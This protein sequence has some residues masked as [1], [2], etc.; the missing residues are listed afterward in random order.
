MW[1]D[2]KPDKIYLEIRVRNKKMTVSR[3]RMTRRVNDVV[4]ARW[5]SG[6]FAGYQ[7][8]ASKC[9]HHCNPT[10]KNSLIH[11]LLIRSSRFR[12]C[13]L[14]FLVLKRCFKRSWRGDLSFSR[15][16][17]HFTVSNSRFLKN[18]QRFW[19]KQTNFWLLRKTN[20]LFLGEYFSRSINV[21]A[22]RAELF[23]LLGLFGVSML[24]T[25]QNVC[26]SGSTVF[27]P[28]QVKQRKEECV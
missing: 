9:L 19:E 1:Q 23:G 3:G 8:W 12:R 17:F 21:E 4:N 11:E 18:I 26:R 27:H 2:R 14:C 20:S 22:N 10:R 16:D 7:W 6:L 13:D 5:S 25:F 24:I 15:L 28:N